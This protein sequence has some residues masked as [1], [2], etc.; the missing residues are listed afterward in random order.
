MKSSK[1]ENL[2][3]IW[4]EELYE[5]CYEKIGVNRLCEEEKEAKRNESENY[6]KNGMKYSHWIIYFISTKE[7]GNYLKNT[8]QSFYT[9]LNG[10]ELMK[11]LNEG[12]F[13][14]KEEL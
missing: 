13:I 14:K 2:M 6:K 1:F 8:S 9:S 5:L 7:A 3:D 10:R 4:Y 12:D 11:I